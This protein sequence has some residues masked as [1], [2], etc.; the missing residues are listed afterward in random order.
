MQT[1]LWCLRLLP[2]TIPV[3]A[4]TCPELWSRFVMKCTS[5]C[6]SQLYNLWRMSLQKLATNLK[7][8]T[9]DYE[10]CLEQFYVNSKNYFTRMANR[11]QHLPRRRNSKTVLDKAKHWETPLSFYPFHLHLLSIRSKNY[12]AHYLLLRHPQFMFLS[13]GQY[14]FLSTEWTYNHFSLHFK[15]KVK[16][17]TLPSKLSQA[18]TFRQQY[19]SA[20]NTTL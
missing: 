7:T 12:L 5:A 16:F 4:P 9:S 10:L 13:Q 17:S 20:P 15:C 14:C 1:D 18:V 11:S 3:Q 19:Q 8:G 2:R 6:R